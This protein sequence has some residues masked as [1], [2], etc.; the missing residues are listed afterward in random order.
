MISRNQS[1]VLSA[2]EQGNRDLSAAADRVWSK[3][4]LGRDA[5]EQVDRDRCLGQV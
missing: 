3:L 4:K 1:A 2:A 5:A